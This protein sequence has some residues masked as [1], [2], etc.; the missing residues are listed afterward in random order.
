MNSFNH[1]QSPAKLSLS[2]YTVGWVCALH[3]EMAAAQAMLD[4][5]HESLPNSPF[6]SNTYILGRM[7]RHNVVIACLPTDGYGIANAANVGTNMNRSFPSICWRLMVGVGGGVP[8]K[9]DVRL[10]DIVVGKRTEQYDLGKT[11]QD[12]RFQRMPISQKPP[13]KLRTAVTKLRAHHES[14]PSM[15]PTILSDMFKRY[16]SMTRYT[17][18]GI[19]Q[20]RLF[21]SSYDH[22]NSMVSCES[23]DTSKLVERPARTATDPKI[24]YGGIASGNQVMK[25]GK[26]RDQL[27]TELNVICFEMEA[28]GLMDNFPCL[29]IRGICDY[30]D[31]HKNKRWQEYAAATAAA[32]AKELLSIVSADEIRQPL[33]AEMST[34][35]GKSLC[36]MHGAAAL[37]M[38]L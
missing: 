5:V 26:T 13:Y 29:V 33:M 37:L 28:A 23:C 31:S 10:G 9:V 22:D 20:D 34:I 4:E 30:S 8:G 1:G 17:H 25:D 32:Y 2:D 11:V 38:L 12:G 36:L 18:P 14:E 35:T 27:A 15:L 16:P 19:F 6:D 24:H 3:I 21:H 7:G